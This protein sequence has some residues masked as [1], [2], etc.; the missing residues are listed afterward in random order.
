M[1]PCNR[2]SC[3]HWLRERGG[4]GAGQ[5]GAR[6]AISC[7][8]S[9]GWS[10]RLSILPALALEKLTEVPWQLG[11]ELD[12]HPGHGMGEGHSGRMQGMPGVEERGLGFGGQVL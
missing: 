12:A 10:G 2:D 9:Y 3:R 5:R 11:P 1:N 8:S 6:G 7:R 4:T